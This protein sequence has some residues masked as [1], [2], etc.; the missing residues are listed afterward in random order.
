MLYSKLVTIYG[1]VENTTKTLEK[2][3]IL[4]D[5]LKNVAPKELEEITLLLQGLAF[6]EYDARDLGLGIQLAIKAISS[7]GGSSIDQVKQLWKK[8]GDLGETASQI[9]GNKKQATLFSRSLTTSKVLGNLHKLSELEGP[10]TVDRKISLLK[11]LL[12]SSNGE[13]SKYLVRICLNDLRIG[14]GEGVMR[15]SIAL[16]FD[17]DKVAVQKAYDTTTDFGEVA[18]LAKN[19]VNQLAAATITTGKP[20]KVMLYQKARNITHAFERVGRPGAL[21]YKY[22]GFHIQIHKRA[23]KIQV[24]TRRQEDVTKQFPDIISMVKKQVSATNFILDAEAIGSDPK[25]GKWLPFQHISQ[26][27]RRKYDVELLAKKIPVVVRVFDIMYLDGK[28][29]LLVPFKD[30][31]KAIEKIIKKSQQFAPAEQIVTSSDEDGSR[32]Y[33]ESLEKGNEGLIAKNLEAEYKPGSRVGYGVKIKPIM[34]PLD[35]VIVGA[36]WGTG[37]R[38]GWLSSFI[39]ACKKDDQ[40]LEIGKMGTGI[41]EKEDMG[42]SFKELTKLLKPLIIADEGRVVRVKPK[43]VIEIAYEEIQKSP[44]YSSGFALRFPRLIRMRPDKNLKEIASLQQV[45]TLNLNQRHNN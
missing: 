30:R 26:R 27:I 8:T 36:E 6:P 23:S 29:M 18:Q 43:V 31:R 34:E 25:T 12:A 4:A 5:F 16:A 15:D 7:A 11:E 32:F 22:D 9:M 17:V 28:D 19:G 1:R 21:E 38:G 10:G 45:K 44:T 13:E 41:K 3:A 42:T 20:I 2:T 40:F 14:I 37:K 39:L 24:F 33:K 35:L